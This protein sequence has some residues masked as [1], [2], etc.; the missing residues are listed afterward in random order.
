MSDRRCLTCKHWKATTITKRTCCHRITDGS[1]RII[2][3]NPPAWIANGG[4][5]WAYLVTDP[6][7]GCTLWEA[8]P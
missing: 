3:E 8:K 5:A 6:D 2:E 4:D 1:E 7:F